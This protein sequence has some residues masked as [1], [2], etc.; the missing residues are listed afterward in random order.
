[1]HTN[2]LIEKIQ[3]FRGYFYG[4]NRGSL[5]HCLDDS[6]VGTVYRFLLDNLKG[7]FL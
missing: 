3:A 7:L 5:L 4:F 2:Q 1:M 6:E